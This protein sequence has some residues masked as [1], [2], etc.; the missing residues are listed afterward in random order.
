MK[1]PFQAQLART[2]RNVSQAL[3]KATTKASGVARHGMN[4]KIAQYAMQHKGRAVAMGAMG[5]GAAQ[6]VSGRTRRG[7]GVSKTVGR[8][9]GMY[10]Y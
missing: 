5:L 7:P 3:P 10:K 6:Y 2:G 9:T 4:T 1:L 8:P